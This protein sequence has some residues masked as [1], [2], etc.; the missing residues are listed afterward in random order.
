M[1]YCKLAEEINSTSI[2]NEIAD[3][4][5]VALKVQR[6]N[7]KW[8]KTKNFKVQIASKNPKYIRN[9]I[10]PESPFK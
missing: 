2:M 8:S 4:I 9:F 6:D 3:E 10:N 5:I 7:E 1:H